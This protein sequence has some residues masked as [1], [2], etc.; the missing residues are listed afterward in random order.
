MCVGSENGSIVITDYLWL[1]FIAPK[2]SSRYFRQKSPIFKVSSLPTTVRAQDEKSTKI[3]STARRKVGSFLL[4][5]LPP[6]LPFCLPF[7]HCLPG[8]KICATPASEGR[9]EGLG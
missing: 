1:L 8:V 5:L 7:V 4:P 9:G 6:S 3:A 2:K